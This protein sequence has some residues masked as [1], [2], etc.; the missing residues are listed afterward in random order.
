[1]PADGLA[2]ILRIPRKGGSP[3]EVVSRRSEEETFPKLRSEEDWYPLY[4]LQATRSVENQQ[5]NRFERPV[6]GKEQFTNM[7]MRA[8]KEEFRAMGITFTSSKITTEELLPEG[9]KV[10]SQHTAYAIP[11]LDLTVLTLEELLCQIRIVFKKIHRLTQ[12]RKECMR[13]LANL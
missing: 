9:P 7:T 3:G 6:Q 13:Q 8:R 1:M 10:A 5:G 11:K 4:V 2:Q 12:Q